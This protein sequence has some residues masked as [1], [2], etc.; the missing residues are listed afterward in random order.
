[1]YIECQYFIGYEARSAPA[2]DDRPP[3]TQYPADAAVSFPRNHRPSNSLNAAG[4]L[5]PSIHVLAKNAAHIRRHRARRGLKT[6]P[7]RQQG[8]VMAFKV[9]RSRSIIS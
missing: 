4:D 6:P 3:V 7:R 5:S 2:P 8:R 9:D 1:M